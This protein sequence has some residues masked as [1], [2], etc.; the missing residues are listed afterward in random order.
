[1]LKKFYQISLRTRVP[2]VPISIQTRFFVTQNPPKE[3]EV[4]QEEVKEMQN[5]LKKFEQAMSLGKYKD[6]Q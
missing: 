4:P 6:A 2:F 1:M 5:D 3:P